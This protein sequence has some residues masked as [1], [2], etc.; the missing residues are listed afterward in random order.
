MPDIITLTGNEA[1]RAVQ[2][3]EDFFLAIT[4]GQEEGY[5][6]VVKILPEPSKY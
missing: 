5:E 6:T 1:E 2:D 3:V 4:K